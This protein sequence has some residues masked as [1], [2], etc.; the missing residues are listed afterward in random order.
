MGS[1]RRDGKR[2]LELL[3]ARKTP[4]KFRV[5]NLPAFPFIGPIPVAR[6]AEPPLRTRRPD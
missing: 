2:R 3:K 6:L 4:A 5:D 1:H